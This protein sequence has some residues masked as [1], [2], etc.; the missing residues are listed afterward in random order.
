MRYRGILIDLDMTLF[1][2][3]AGNRIAVGRLLDEV[4][5]RAPDRFEAY[6]AVNLA[7]WAALERGEMTQGELRYIRFRRFF[8]QRGIDADPDVAADRFV[9]LLGEQALL[10]P[11]AEEVA[12]RIAAEKPLVL[13]TNGIS[14]VQR[15]RLARSPLKDV[16]A[17]M[18]VSEEAGVAKP[19][20]GLFNLAL[21][22]HGWSRREALMIGDSATSD[23]AGANAA[24][25]DACWLNP[26]GK[27]LPRGVHAEYV[28]RDL[29]E[30]VEI[31]MR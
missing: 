4:G 23:I 19:H 16:A 27:P 31:A 20:P 10:L 21:K 5:Y 28:I 8:A 25:I 9:A 22:K 3:D 12:R 6:E 24:G 18:I 17:D 29:R 11:H 15:A 1:D 26:A 14:A 2:F 13:L 7:C 30:C